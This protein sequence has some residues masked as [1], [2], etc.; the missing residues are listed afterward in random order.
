M[1]HTKSFNRIHT[2]FEWFN[3]I[4]YNIFVE[5]EYIYFGIKIP[6]LTTSSHTKICVN[7]TIV[8]VLIQKILLEI[9]FDILKFEILHVNRRE[10]YNLFRS[11]SYQVERTQYAKNVMVLAHALVYLNTTVTL[12]LV[13]DLSVFK[14]LN[15]IKHEPVSIINALIH[16]LAYAHPMRVSHA[17]ISSSFVFIPQ[18]T[19]SLHFI[20]VSFFL[21]HFCFLWKI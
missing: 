15:V 18:T 14:I 13:A 11:S 10:V 5:Y 19:Y 7:K 17:R 16:V 4:W 3:R 9:F 8:D 21:N 6:Q 12:T 20:D 2:K 1:C